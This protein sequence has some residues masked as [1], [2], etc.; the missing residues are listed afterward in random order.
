MEGFITARG[1]EG[2]EA[3]QTGAGGGGNTVHKE[4]SRERDGNIKS[5]WPRRACMSQHV[6]AGI[7]TVAVC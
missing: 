1:F 2:R 7:T 5:P 6:E 4:T 3:E